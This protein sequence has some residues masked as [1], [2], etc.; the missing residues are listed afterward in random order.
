MFRH[1][2]F[3][4]LS[5]VGWVGSSISQML[6]K[7]KHGGWYKPRQELLVDARINDKKTVIFSW[8]KYK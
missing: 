7:L 3:L 1:I 4:V 6:G 2:Y 5:W 8:T